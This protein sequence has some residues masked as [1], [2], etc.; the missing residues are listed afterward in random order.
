MVSQVTLGNFFNVNGRT[1]LGGAG[2]SGLDTQAL[3]TALM[4]ARQVPVKTLQDKIAVN[5]KK[6]SAL[7]DLKTL[8]S[9]F[10]D[11]SNFLRN[12]P[13]VGNETDNIFAYRSASMTS[14]TSVDGSTYLNVTA[15]PGAAIG[16]YHINSI[17]SVATAKKQATEVLGV[18]TTTESVVKSGVTAHYFKEGTITLNGQAITLNTSDSLDTVVA[19]FNA[20]K[21]FTGIGASILQVDDGQ[22]R[23]VFTATQT[24]EDADFDLGADVVEDGLDGLTFSELQGA[25]NAEFK[26]DNVTIFRQTNTISDLVPNV[27]FELKQ[28]TPALTTVDVNIQADQTTAQNGILNFVNSYNDLRVF[29]AKQTKLG[30]DGKYTEDAVL[31]TDSMMRS[32]LNTVS[33]QMS[34]VVAG[35]SGN[36]QDLSSAG[37]TFADLPESKDNPFTRNILNV[38]TQK[39][40]A[41]LAGNFD[42]VRKIFEF[43]GTFDSASF[44]VYSRSNNV[45]A[46]SADIDVHRATA[47][48]QRTQTFTITDADTQIAYTTPG[49][50][51]FG[52]GAITFNGATITLADGD[53]LNQVISKFNAVEATSHIHAS[54]D[55]V[56]AGQYRILFTADAAGT[57]TDFDLSSGSTVTAGSS[58]LS[59]ITFSTTQAASNDSF[60]ATTAAGA[61]SLTATAIT[62]GGYRLQ[63]AAGS[64]L[65]GLVVIYG[66]STSASATLT[67]TQGIAD[68]LWN[69]LDGVLKDT[70]GLL[71][72]DTDAVS[73]N[74]T[75]LNDEI[76][77]LNEQNDRYREQLVTKFTNLESALS[78]INSLLTA[79]NAQDQARNNQ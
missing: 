19:K 22:Y 28:A 58:F 71:A 69:T 52:A 68:K 12:P 37:I 53:T 23:V 15:G 66:E 39:L 49:A 48:T 55:T 17:T 9:K 34:S 62:G 29:A 35:L 64:D 50:D 32:L 44:R 75:R 27:T 38:N 43:T 63:G 79:L 3:M 31:A 24:G 11:A 20:V 51:Q 72:T 61:Q 76:S 45:T 40:G 42:D 77:R 2:G 1:V 54:L 4:N 47:K 30:A 60:T 78:S 36:F 33:A 46:S 25:H 13:G 74:T 14:N 18:S 6:T 67:M 21:S 8:L 26:V 56:A 70:T 65:D 10:K 57:S 41:A 73:A 7:S 5:D 16:N 59:N